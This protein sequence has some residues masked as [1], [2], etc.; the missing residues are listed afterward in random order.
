MSQC[1]CFHGI[2]YQPITPWMDKI[3]SAQME[4]IRKNFPSVK[5]MNDTPLALP[6]DTSVAAP[7]K[8]SPVVIEYGPV[9]PVHTGYARI[10]NAITDALRGKSQELK[11]SVYDII[12]SD[13]LPNNVHGVEETDRLARI[14][15]GVEKAEYLANQFMDERSRGS[16]MDAMRSIAKI[17]MEG[18]RVGSCKMEYQVKHAIGLDGN[19]YVHEDSRGE[20]RYAMEMYDTE[21]YAEYQKMLNASG[22]DTGESAM[23]LMRW[24]LKNIDLVVA[25]RPGYQKYQDE[26]YEKLY[27][28]KL[29]CTFSGTDKSSKD[30]FLSSIKEKLNANRNL[31]IDMF[32]EQISQMAKAPGGYLLGRRMVLTG[33]A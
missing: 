33:R 13:F 5:P 7:S 16:F 11:D 29:D 19:G 24:M 1:T 12:R 9:R 2:G 26:Q 32:M 6:K 27:Q 3:S 28:V 18:K 30:S 21:S 17:G 15:L 10:D 20:V 14:S 4:Q 25:G 31:Q 23:F 8:P 22:E